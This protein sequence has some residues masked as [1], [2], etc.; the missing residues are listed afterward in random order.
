MKKR[1]TNRR[2]RR[3]RNLRDPI[4]KRHKFGTAKIFIL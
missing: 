3:I 4:S 1:W 2:E